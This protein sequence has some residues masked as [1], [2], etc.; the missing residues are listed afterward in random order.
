MQHT[1]E[2]SR[3]TLHGAFSAELEPAVSMNPGDSIR[4]DTVD[5]AWGIGQH[6]RDSE[7]RPKIEPRSKPR[8]DGPALV[9]PI[10]VQGVQPGDT[11]AV[12]LDR[13][14]PSTWGW[15]WW[16]D[17]PF[18]Q[19]LN[20]SVGFEPA[21]ANKLLLWEIDT[22]AGVAISE[23]GDRVA[24]SPFLGTLGLCPAGDGW[25]T[26]WF[27]TRFGGNL[28][29]S[30]LVEGTTIYLPVG[31]SGAL[32]S[33]GDAHAAQGDGEIA[34]SAIE[35]CMERVELTVDFADGLAVE[36]P[37]ADTPTGWV[38]LGVGE[39]LDDAVAMAT[40]GML[41]VLRQQFGVSA[42]RA[43]LLASSLVDLRV[44]QLVNKVRGVHAVLTHERAKGIS[45]ETSR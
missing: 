39:S 36:V 24:L 33:L 5:V 16:G 19:Q 45:R 13:L 3:Q 38:T 40:R 43:M 18:N 15:T 37:T 30:E 12:T 27:P 32:L 2:A 29:C 26:G 44:T 25:H 34:G 42:P 35:I 41:D 28:D 14:V 31:V 10:H 21:D 4:C 17:G 1:I 8:D 7:T 11:L 9:G 6:D 20:E 22:D 23:H